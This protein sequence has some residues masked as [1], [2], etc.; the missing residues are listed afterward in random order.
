MTLSHRLQR[1]QEPSRPSWSCW[2]SAPRFLVPCRTS[3][4]EV[5]TK[6]PLLKADAGP[7]TRWREMKRRKKRKLRHCHC[8]VSKIRK[9]V[10]P[11]RKRCQSSSPLLIHPVKARSYERRYS[12]EVG[13]ILSRQSQTWTRLLQYLKG[14]SEAGLAPLT[15]K[16]SQGESG[17]CTVSPPGSMA[18]DRCTFYLCTWE[19]C[20][21]LGAQCLLCSLLIWKWKWFSSYVSPFYDHSVS[22]SHT[23]FSSNGTFSVSVLFSSVYLWWKRDLE[24][25]RK[26]WYA[27]TQQNSCQHRRS[28]M[29][30]MHHLF[31]AWLFCKCAF[32]FLLNLFFFPWFY[33]SVN[34]TSTD[35]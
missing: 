4:S 21:Q 8:R 2:R 29:A 34:F 11:G 31:C 5:R 32:A 25:Q 26:C 1:A 16:I 23:I 35:V 12:L 14:G 30:T 27:L 3:P 18:T 17:S 28:W 33:H 24:K 7:L 13:V 20:I 19:A 10:V 9:G 15:P 6:V 22:P